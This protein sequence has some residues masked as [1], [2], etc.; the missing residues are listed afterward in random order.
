M[1]R[2]LLLLC[3][4]TL[5]VGALTLHAATDS[6][7][8]TCLAEG[9]ILK[10]W[11]PLIGITRAHRLT[12]QCDGWVHR[13]AFKTLDMRKPGLY[14]H[15]DGSREFNFTDS[16]K[17]EV[18]AYLLDRELGLGMVPVAVLRTYRGTDGAL[19]SWISNTV[20]E[21]QVTR[22]FNGVEM[23]SLERQ[24][25]IVRLFDSLIYNTDRRPPNLLVDESEARVYMIDHG[26]S[27]REQ[28]KLQEG[29]ASSRVWI[30]EDSYDR[31]KA[32]DRERLDELLGDLTTRGQRK[33]L[34]VR[35]DLIIEKIE[36]DRQTV[37]DEAVFV[38]PAQ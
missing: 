16:Y 7:I 30:S 19:V 8:A 20:H 26:R 38:E 21:N 6:E 34:L 5:N 18:A 29:F 9:E 33:T 31:L 13:A 23:A 10:G 12:L 35:R 15:D 11:E 17:Y 28:K 22:K 14:V 37:G 25:S 2:V 4:V 24:K 36:S 1:R 27:F 32:L 3:L